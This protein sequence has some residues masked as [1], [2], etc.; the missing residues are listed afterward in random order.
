MPLCCHYNIVYVHVCVLPILNYEM[1]STCIH[2]LIN[3]FQI[4]YC[5]LSC[6]FSFS[7]FF[8]LPVRLFSSST[9]FM[10]PLLMLL[11]GNYFG[12]PLFK[13]TQIQY[14]YQ[15]NNYIEQKMKKK[16]EC[17]DHVVVVVVSLILSCD[18]FFIG[19]HSFFF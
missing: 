13:I 11:F 2:F 6:F 19:N 1:N 10:F 4:C 9:F 16:I 12:L 7:S 14:L 17:F 15:H 3:L 8:L 18:A 5:W